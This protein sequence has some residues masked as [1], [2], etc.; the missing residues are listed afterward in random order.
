MSA[1]RH[2]QKLVFW[3]KEFR[4]RTAVDKRSAPLA[5][6]EILDTM[7][8]SEIYNRVYVLEQ[9]LRNSSSP[10]VSHASI[11]YNAAQIVEIWGYL[12][13]EESPHPHERL[14]DMR[15]ILLGTILTLVAFHSGTRLDDHDFG[16]GPLFHDYPAIMASLR[17]FMGAMQRIKDEPTALKTLQYTI[18]EELIRSARWIFPTNPYLSVVTVTNIAIAGLNS[19]LELG[20]EVSEELMTYNQ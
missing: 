1:L 18:A 3:N 16:L 13:R 9:N 15:A 4:D 5:E 10:V 17:G 2:R 8:R 7:S 14:L 6:F 20:Y 19:G 11:M 12:K